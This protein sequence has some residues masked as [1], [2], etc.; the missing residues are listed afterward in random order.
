MINV[1][2]STFESF[3]CC[4]WWVYTI[5]HVYAEP[6]SQTEAL[7]TMGSTSVFCNCIQLILFLLT[8]KAMFYFASY[9]PICTVIQT[10]NAAEVPC[11]ALTFLL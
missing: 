9:S 7:Y 3:Q 6:W 2:H 5:T 4:G 10:Q 1:I 11:K 8:D